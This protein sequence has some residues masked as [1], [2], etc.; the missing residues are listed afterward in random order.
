M[1]ASS[2]GTGTDNSKRK[3]IYHN[4]QSLAFIFL[5]ITFA[6]VFNFYYYA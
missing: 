1:L 2:W 3:R 4:A 6:L 5:F